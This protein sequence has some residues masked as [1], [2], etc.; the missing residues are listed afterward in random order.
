[1]NDLS[2]IIKDR[3]EMILERIDQAARKV[4]RIGSEIKIVAVSKGQPVEVIKSALNAGLR[5]FGENYPSETLVKAQELSGEY[6]IEWHMIG[7]LQS[8]K[9]P[10]IANIFSFYHS[11]DRLEVVQKMDSYLMPQKKTLPVMLEVNVSGEDSKGGIKMEGNESIEKI[12]E[13]F[14]QV[15][16]LQNIHLCGLMTMPP[17]SENPENS[18]E[19]FRKLNKLKEDIND[20]L[21]CVKLTELSMGTSFDFTIAVEEGATFVRI[22]NALL[23]ERTVP[24]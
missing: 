22:G 11:L 5:C 6:N 4:G 2:T 3:H 12:V 16:T 18:R 9:I 14:R 8:R 13:I 21:P 19:W 15:S 23:G 17:F 20:R 10:I 1:M 7:H 24:H